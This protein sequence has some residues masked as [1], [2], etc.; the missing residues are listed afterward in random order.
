MFVVDYTYKHG[1]IQ[2]RPAVGLRVEI[3]PAACAMT[4]AR[5]T[6]GLAVGIACLALVITPA[7]AQSS[8]AFDAV[9][10]SLF[11]A[12]EAP[13]GYINETAF[14]SLYHTF[15]GGVPEHVRYSVRCELASP[16]DC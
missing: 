1:K 16:I 14:E 8:S 4:L 6:L 13:V 10:D 12:H 2:S 11:S 3:L 15:L 7:A 5:V 9:V